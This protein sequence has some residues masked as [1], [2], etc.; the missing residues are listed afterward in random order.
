MVNLE[1]LLPAMRSTF[2]TAMAATYLYIDA[3][4]VG[5]IIQDPDKKV[6]FHESDVL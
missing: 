2:T 1:T 3:E 6:N 5:A 4:L